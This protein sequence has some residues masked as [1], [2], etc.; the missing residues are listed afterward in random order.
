[1][2]PPTL[3]EVVWLIAIAHVWARGTIFRYIRKHGPRVWVALADCPLCAGFWIGV[4]GHI[5]FQRWPHVVTLL[6]I[7]SVVGTLAL[8]TCALIRRL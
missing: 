1:M 2:S 6:G 5:A 3:V 4:L 8:G 7:G